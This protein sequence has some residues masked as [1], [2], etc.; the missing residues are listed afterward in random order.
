MNVEFKNI[1]FVSLKTRLVFFNPT[2]F[3]VSVCSL[4]INGLCRRKRDKRIAR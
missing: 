4:V 1:F 2:F 3:V